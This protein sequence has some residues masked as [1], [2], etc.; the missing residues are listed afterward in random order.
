MNFAISECGW[1]Q[2]FRDV[3]MEAEDEGKSRVPQS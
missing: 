3:Y 1:K 2:K